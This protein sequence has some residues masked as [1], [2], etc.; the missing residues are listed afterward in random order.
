M[1]AA[2]LGHAMG[3]GVTTFPRG[4]PVGCHRGEAAGHQ[5]SKCLPIYEPVWSSWPLVR[6]AFS[7]QFTED[8][9]LHRGHFAQSCANPS[10]VASGDPAVHPTPASFAANWSPPPFPCGDAPS[11]VL[12]TTEV[13]EGHVHDSQLLVFHLCQL[14]DGRAAPKH[15]R[16]NA[17]TR[18]VVGLSVSTSGLAL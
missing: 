9:E 16:Q 7:P 3:S 2:A 15:V 17:G 6:G 14:S 5:P 18:P 1:P 13:I 8:T 4:S 10:M 12:R 11:R